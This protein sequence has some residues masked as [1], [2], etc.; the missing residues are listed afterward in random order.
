M[1]EALI[2]FHIR[3][4][5]SI[6]KPGVKK[7]KKKGELVAEGVDIT[8]IIT[9]ADSQTLEVRLVCVTARYLASERQLVF[10]VSLMQSDVC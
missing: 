5:G 2:A 10:S 3:F 6:W 7:K 8:W 1:C 9:K 4:N